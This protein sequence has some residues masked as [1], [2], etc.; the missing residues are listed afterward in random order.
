VTSDP[1]TT[2]PLGSVTN[3][4]SDPVFTCAGNID[5]QRRMKRI[6]NPK[7][8]AVLLWHFNFSARARW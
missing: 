8:V 7:F 1:A 4:L 5:T 2:A 6:K 3:P